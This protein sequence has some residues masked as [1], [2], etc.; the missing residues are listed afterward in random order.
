M[1]TSDVAAL[2]VALVAALATMSAVVTV[3]PEELRS[4]LL[5]AASPSSPSSPSPPPSIT[6]SEESEKPESEPRG[7]TRGPIIPAAVPIERRL[8]PLVASGLTPGEVTEE[9]RPALLRNWSCVE[10]IA[11]VHE[12]TEE[13]LRESL[14]GGGWA[15]R[16][17]RGQFHSPVFRLSEVS[18]K[19][20][21]A[22]AARR[23]ERW[24]GVSGRLEGVD[25]RFGL[26]FEGEDPVENFDGV[27]FGE[28]VDT[29]AAV[30]VPFLYYTVPLDDWEPTGLAQRAAGWEALRVSDPGVALLVEQGGRVVGET[31]GGAQSSA[32][33]AASVGIEEHGVAMLWLSQPG[34]TAHA[35]YDKSHNF[36]TQIMG[37]KRVLL[38]P[39]HMGP[40]LYPFPHSHPS[41]HQSA[42]NFEEPDLLKFPDFDSARA[43]EVMME[44]GDCLYIPPYWWHRIETLSPQHASP[45]AP[46]PPTAST[47]CSLALSVV[48]PSAEEARLASAYWTPLPFSQTSLKAKPSALVQVRSIAVQSFLVHLLSRLGRSPR[49]FA[50]TLRLSRFAALFPESGLST[51]RRTSAG[52]SGAES[53]GADCFA[54]DAV[55]S[56]KVRKGLPQKAIATAAKQIAAL[57]DVQELSGEGKRG[58]QG[59][60]G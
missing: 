48:S 3:L 36:L 20:D 32:D 49:S 39:P 35:H 50:Q 30:D 29:A 10:S 1:G 31:E 24:G 55:A 18:D 27:P 15:L 11:A 14:D 43:L 40:L 9:R 37:R 45:T 5:P 17:V 8:E 25:D 47:Q 26:A 53:S 42:V 41:Y 54:Q 7:P 33:D 21:S 34:V 38:W 22:T 46:E 16:H 44:P 59:G 23:D 12:W 57:I 6:P 58:R 60:V 2:V 56:E 52:A 4:L 19:N 28:F 51:L 13:S